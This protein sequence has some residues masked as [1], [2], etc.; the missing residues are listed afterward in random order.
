MKSRR[1][2]PILTYPTREIAMNITRPKFMF[3]F[4]I[5]LATAN[6]QTVLFESDG[7]SLA[8]F[9]CDY[10]QSRP[11]NAFVNNGDGLPAPSIEFNSPDRT[12][13]RAA[14]YTVPTLAV[15]QQFHGSLD[16]KVESATGLPS[17]AFFGMP[18]DSSCTLGDFPYL[19]TWPIPNLGVRM[20]PQHGSYE[21]I[22]SSGPASQFLPAGTI[23]MA[24][25]QWHHIELILEPQ[26]NGTSI[27][28]FLLDGSVIAHD[29]SADPVLNRDLGM[30]IGI[31]GSGEPTNVKFD[32][33]LVEVR[34]A[35]IAPVTVYTSR[36]A[37]ENATGSSELT[38]PSWDSL[39]IAPAN[40]EPESGA[41]EVIALNG[42]KV[43]ADLTAPAARPFG[44][45]SNA[46]FI[47]DR[48]SI[49]ANGSTSL[50]PDP[51]SPVILANGEDDY[52]LVFSSPVS[53]V[54]FDVVSNREGSESVTLRDVAG[55]VIAVISDT[56][57][58]TSPNSFEFFGFATTTPIKTVNINT[59]GGALQN[60]G[61]LSV[62]AAVPAA[63]GTPVLTDGTWYQFANEDITGTPHGCPP[64]DPFFPACNPRPGT[65]AAAGPPPWTFLAPAGG[66]DLTVV[67]DGV[68]GESYEIFDNGVSIGR[69]N[70]V[71][72]GPTSVTCFDPDVCLADARYTRGTFFLP[73]GPH[74]ITIPYS[75]T[76]NVNSDGSGYFRVQAAGPPAPPPSI[77]FLS[78][79]HDTAGS[80][81]KIRGA[82]FGA[83]QGL[84]TINFG[85]VT[86]SVKTWF[87]DVVKITVPNLPQGTYQVSITTAGGTSNS[88]PFRVRTTTTSRTSPPGGSTNPVGSFA[89]PVNTATGAYYTVKTD[90]VV[91]GKGLNF[92]FTRVYNSQ[93]PNTGPLGFG[94]SHS[95]FMLLSEDGVSGD[96][97]I[98]QGD[99]GAISFAKQGDG[100]Y[101]ASTPGSF[102]SLESTGDGEFMLRRKNQT[103]IHFVD[104][105]P[106]SIVDR[107]GNEQTMTYDGS[108]RL[109]TVTD[110][111]SRVFTFGY[112][113]EDHIISL[114][115]PIGRV[116]A[117]AYD[118]TG[119]LVSYTNAAGDTTQ[120]GYDAAHRMLTMTDPLGNVVFTNT[121][122]GAGRV[123][124]QTNARGFQTTFEY[125]TPSAGVTS[126][127]DAL[128]NVL[129]HVHDSNNRL[130]QVIDA[131]GN[132]TTFAYNAQNLRS[133]VTDALGRTA[134]FSY[135]AAGNLLQAIDPAGATSTFAYDS[136][137]NLT[138]VVDRLGRTTTF[139]YD[140]N[141]NLSS[142]QNALGYATT[143]S[144]D[145]S[146]LLKTATNARGAVTQ[147]EYDAHGRLSKV[148]DAAGEEI[149]ISNDMVGRPFEA[150]NQLGNVWTRSF[151][152]LNRL[153]SVLDPLGNQTGFAYDAN[154]NLVEVTDANGNSTE[155]D[156]DASNNLVQVTDAEGGITQYSYDGNND[157]VGLT[158]ANGHTR[159][160]MYDAVRR[161]S[162]V[163]DPLGR[164]TQYTY[165]A[166]G[167]IVQTDDAKGQTNAYAYDL[168]DRL[169]SVALDDSRSIGY[170]YD[171]EGNRLEMNDWTGKT[172]YSYD[173]LNR[174]LSVVSPDGQPVAY[175]YDEVGNRT[176]LGYPD[177]K[178]V[179]YSYDPQN[180]LAAVTDWNGG[181]T[182]Y[183]Y[184]LAGNVLG[185]VHPNGADSTYSY[186]AAN[187]LVDIV[188]KV[189][190]QPVSSFT[191]ALDAVGNRIGV[192][193]VNGGFT[194]YGYD[195]LYRLTSWSPPGGPVTT[196]TYDPVGN[197]LSELSG[198]KQTLYEYDP[199]D[200]LLKAGKHVYTYDQ[201]GNIAS[202]LHVG[203]S[204]AIPNGQ[205]A[206]V[207]YAFDALNRLIAV[208]GLGIDVEFVYD[209]DRNRVARK[210][211][212]Q[213]VAYLND[214]LTPLP[215]VLTQGRG[216]NLIANVWGLGLVSSTS[217][218]NQLFAQ[219]DG[220]GSTCNLSTSRGLPRSSY[221]YDPWGAFMGAPR[222]Q[223]SDMPLFAG[224]FSEVEADLIYLRARYYDISSG[225]FVSRDS[226]PA[227]I[228]SPE[229]LNRYSYV[230]NNPPNLIDPSG[231]LTCYLGNKKSS[232]GRGSGSSLAFDF[233]N[234][235]FGF[236]DTSS[237]GLEFGAITHS[238]G[239]APGGLAD[240]AGDAY[241][242][243][244]TPGGG[245]IPYVASSGASVSTNY[246]VALEYQLGGT[247]VTITKE[248]TEV[249]FVDYLQ[250]LIPEISIPG[251]LNFQH[252]YW[253][254]TDAQ[255]GI[256]RNRPGY[257]TPPT[258]SPEVFPDPKAP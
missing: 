233:D 241:R 235:R 245:G 5:A 212:R 67:D 186:D 2:P 137:D 53:A 1:S 171:A 221:D 35:A 147:F 219:F 205:G 47:W 242:F 55:T 167:N 22:S 215:V 208:Q 191:Y 125:N 223:P 172:A 6:G 105:L 129:Q 169:V 49:L 257:A 25:G 27:F 176:A 183:Q 165:D 94:W 72:Q 182:T 251:F 232:I 126:V 23:P 151:D 104:G 220:L 255:S 145:S 237:T 52:Q 154:G 247:P 42:T 226:A 115:D 225:R 210:E 78:P 244:A 159:A 106:V 112:D 156:F 93:N 108:G 136:K 77:S 101:E 138:S 192:T 230:Y 69:T 239:C 133:S 99:G 224:E 113:A 118:A 116:L 190:S 140:G 30:E 62:L 73:A 231:L 258:L 177:G 31:G 166:V 131:L 100:S 187:R 178:Q 21:Y 149:E 117:Y 185:F 109:A 127:T 121:H 197:R 20:G 10:G 143:F 146:G 17:I 85:P 228:E 76:T 170:V 162:Q 188:N 234:Q 243:G 70:D 33:M 158:D 213:I 198:G 134:T 139:A 92:N 144:Y 246:D 60:E 4:A 75:P 211:R 14:I 123:I 36:F 65:T 110:T 163:I 89:E 218:R 28:Q 130:T 83:S 43:S 91:P 82:N 80:Q 87:D 173:A 88:Q 202:K 66:L 175:S 217:P 32:N 194:A 142:I 164:A 68:A 98:T 180:R 206:V 56:Q 13:R 150:T 195:D 44:P 184:D 58:Q 41:D 200:Q 26:A 9:V 204:G 24:P 201:N 119:D 248:R 227:A 3:A 254:T 16:V 15:G 86:A 74:S 238:V 174:V 12:M 152:P 29:V 46:V 54:G 38:I 124:L 222:R 199:A 107:N 196:W 114:T 128:G 179:S 193:D 59:T 157:L 250:D 132:A 181:T 61:I 111:S 84:S 155:Y 207:N 102:D 11:A 122:D 39:Q 51:S 240:Q 90:L 18:V 19:G 203:T 81:I 48:L 95:Y 45:L 8:P 216:R 209:G 249:T 71:Q 256:L 135:D 141:S 37:F 120:Y 161:A 229:S 40:G 153:L 253:T 79:N 214:T 50:D 97:T 64:A 189:G 96:V 7:S 148:T 160:Y 168:L 34:N 63:P 103:E 57:L 252:L 236:L